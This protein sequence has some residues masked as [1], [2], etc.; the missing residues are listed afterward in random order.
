MLLYPC[1]RNR[2]WART[3]PLSNHC[4]PLCGTKKIVIS[5]IVSP[6]LTS[7]RKP[8]HTMLYDA[9][10]YFSGMRQVLAFFPWLLSVLLVL[11]GRKQNLPWKQPCPGLGRG[12]SL[13]LLGMGVLDDMWAFISFQTTQ[14]GLFTNCFRKLVS[15]CSASIFSWPT[16]L[17]G[18]GS[19]LHHFKQTQASVI[20]RYTHSCS[21]WR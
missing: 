5:A 16:D 14:G 1:S 17:F 3:G 6:L 2:L 19:F 7:S 11:A 10:S 20:T 13:L 15:L 8:P 9:F 18:L 21:L 12:T 4:T